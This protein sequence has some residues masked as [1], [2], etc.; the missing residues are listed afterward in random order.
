MADARFV[1][2][3]VVAERY[4]IVALLG[5]GGMGEVYRADDLTLGTR[6]ALK[7]LP[8]ELAADEDYRERFLDEE[9]LARQVSHPNICRVH[10][11]GE[12]AS[13][14]GAR[15]LFL[16]M[17]YVAGED[18]A[19][20]LR[21][22]GRLPQEKANEIARQICL[23]V[24]AAHDQGILHRDLKP[25]NVLIDGDGRARVADFGLAA[26]AQ[27][28]RGAAAR[29]GTPAYMAPEQL[30]G[31]E[32]S[33]ASD[34]F[35][36]GLVLFE[37]Y[38]GKPAYRAKT[39]EDL[40]R[41]HQ[42]TDPTPSTVLEDIHP[43][44]DATIKRCLARDPKERPRN[45]REVAMSLP[46]GD[47]LAAALAAGETPSLELIAASGRPGTLRPAAA[48]A[49]VAVI[50]S[51]LAF[52]AWFETHAQVVELI[53]PELPIDVLEHRAREFARSAGY[54]TNGG[55]SARGMW[56][57]VPTE[58]NQDADPARWQRLRDPALAALRFWYRYS[59]GK[60]VPT[61]EDGR[62]RASDPPIDRRGMLLVGLGQDG[63][64]TSFRA[65]PPA[66]ARTQPVCDFAVA[67][68]AAGLTASGL[69]EREP[70]FVPPGPATVLRTWAGKHAACEADVQVDAAAF[71]SALTWFQVTVTPRIKER[72]TAP[73]SQLPQRILEISAAVFSLVVL[74]GGI[75]L[76][77]KNLA[78]GRGDRRTATRVALTL[79]TLSMACWLLRAD[80]VAEIGTE[81][82]MLVRQ[83]GPALWASLLAGLLFL[84]IEPT[85]RRAWPE[86]M[87]A[88]SR[89]LTGQFRDPLIGRAVLVGMAC[90]FA[91]MAIAL[92]DWYVAAWMTGR[93]PHPSIL[94][95]DNLVGTRHV[96]AGMLWAPVDGGLAT[97][98]AVFLLALLRWLVKKPA[99]VASA[100]VAL[101]LARMP[102]IVMT[103]LP[104]VDLLFRIPQALLV[105][106]CLIGP[107][108]LALFV[109]V[110]TL[111]LMA[112]TSL[113]PN[114]DAWWSTSTLLVYGAL[115]A[116]IT[117]G[118]VTSVGRGNRA[119]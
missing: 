49:L 9:R 44:A 73:T 25:G 18:L 23:G 50:V 47:P 51:C 104:T 66:T 22:I 60:L 1:P 14:D 39:L 77:A 98:I 15:L 74:V 91:M 110:T 71:G 105:A 85:A 96:L 76:G 72:I 109:M 31:R 101:L 64:L 103:E 53:A 33:A 107:G 70:T 83:M 7:F 12:T 11:V 41:Q 102:Y 8:P 5:R 52:I 97:L 78:Q 89:L 79:F 82:R 2:G 43:A 29:V 3:A 90:A 115:A 69:T 28:L 67:F 87:I 54:E 62:V 55:D 56:L 38:T 68:A 46:G 65:V 16:S 17:E 81:M 19:S 21:R 112:G 106:Y 20:L 92:G 63:R 37:L 34:V 32:V 36:L 26:A 119:A 10:D 116:L 13:S 113:A 108:A 84:A 48:L 99:L 111:N 117:F 88:W 100:L 4:R 118:W 42:E 40:Q 30:A 94:Y 93:E 58:L 45:A 61:V 86:K 24:A 6:V 59:P 80:H 114:F 95:A 75:W 27:T 35:S 57:S